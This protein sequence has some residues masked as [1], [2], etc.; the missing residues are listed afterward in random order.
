M[1]K[2]AIKPED[3]LL[4]ALV[5]AGCGILGYSTGT[6]VITDTHIDAASWITALATCGLLVGAFIVRNDFKEQF[7]HKLEM[8]AAQ[9]I[10]TAQPDVMCLNLGTLIFKSYNLILETSHSIETKTPNQNDYD[11]ITQ[12]LTRVE[13]LLTSYHQ[14][15]TQTSLLKKASADPVYKIFA[16][17]FNHFLGST[18]AIR[19]L[20]QKLTLSKTGYINLFTGSNIDN[21]GP[22]F[23][24]KANAIDLNIVSASLKSLKNSTS[25][26]SPAS[27]KLL[28]GES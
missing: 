4:L 13:T 28:S 15:G 17:D 12:V 3:I 9:F 22:D 21:F 8:E 2:H 10:V 19:L 18:I 16:E 7:H 14:L 5:G 26:L 20:L 1:I 11:E 24:T 27:L 23:L 6:T 25:K